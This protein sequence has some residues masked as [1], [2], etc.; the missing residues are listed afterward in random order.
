MR[1]GD[2]MELMSFNLDEFIENAKMARDYHVDA[3]RAYN[4]VVAS[5]ISFKRALQRLEDVNAK[6][7]AGGEEDAEDRT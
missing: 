4:Q 1:K 5:A 6:Y 2:T 3:K 7:S